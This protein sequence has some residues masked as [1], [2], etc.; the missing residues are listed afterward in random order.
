MDLFSSILSSSVLD[1]IMV[2]TA[3]LS[4]EIA[5]LL[6]ALSAK[7][8][9]AYSN[10]TALYHSEGYDL[11]ITGVGPVMAERTL[12]LYLD[13]HQP[14]RILN[15]GSAGM[16]TQPMELGKTYHISSTLTENEEAIYLDLLKGESGET[17]LSVRRSI[18][19]TD[20]RDNSHKAHGARLAD[21]ECYTLAKIAVEKNIPMSAIKITTDYADCETTDMFKQQIEKSAKTLAEEVQE[22]LKTI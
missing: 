17:C 9:K 8:V 12:K 10:K 6:N 20:R 4:I 7:K 18:N 16:L 22:I 5:P 2:I 21:M 3:A 19:D 1:F 14:D 13:E 15:I 11:L